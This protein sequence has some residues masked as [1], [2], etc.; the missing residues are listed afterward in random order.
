MYNHACVLALSFWVYGSL[1]SLGG[2][3]ASLVQ[4]AILCRF[5]MPLSGEH[6]T[7]GTV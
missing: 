7:S 1:L 6:T 4:S 5:A 3:G 2:Y